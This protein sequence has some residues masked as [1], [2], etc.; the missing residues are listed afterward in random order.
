MSDFILLK[1]RAQ[2]ALNIKVAC[3]AG[4]KHK[5]VSGWGGCMYAWLHVGSRYKLS[6]HLIFQLALVNQSKVG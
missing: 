1:W 6:F 3:T 5:F 2:Q 4:L